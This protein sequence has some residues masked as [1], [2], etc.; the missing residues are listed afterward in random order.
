MTDWYEPSYVR[1]N[2]RQRERMHPYVLSGEVNADDLASVVEFCAGVFGEGGMAAYGYLPHRAWRW[3]YRTFK[4]AGPMSC[5]LGFLTE[6][7]RLVFRMA[8]DQGS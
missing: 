7:D 3:H 1:M 6:A 2:P 8:F 4:D 5:T